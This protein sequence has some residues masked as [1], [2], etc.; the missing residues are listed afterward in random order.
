MKIPTCIA[1]KNTDLT[2]DV[3]ET[4]IPM[5]L[6]EEAMKKSNTCIDFA[7]GKIH[8]FDVEIPVNFNSSGHYCIPI[9]KL[10]YQNIKKNNLNENIN[11]FY[12]DLNG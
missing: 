4:G 12:N 5:L 1:G 6:S 2:T 3:I 9:G 10:D 8:I 7:N 11:L